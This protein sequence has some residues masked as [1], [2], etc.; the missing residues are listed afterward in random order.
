MRRG[1]RLLIVLG[2][3]AGGSLALSGCGGCPVCNF[4]K[5]VFQGSGDTGSPPAAPE[6]AAPGA[7]HA[8]TN[9]PVHGGRINH[10]LYVDCGDKRVY[11]CCPAC[12]PVIR[13]DPAK[14]VQLLE[15]KGIT[16]DRVPKEATQ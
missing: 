7:P 1:V 8:Q 14:Y 2:F 13:K 9:C 5:R 10:Q 4:F 12:I 11:V 16:L 15:A 6:S 3:V